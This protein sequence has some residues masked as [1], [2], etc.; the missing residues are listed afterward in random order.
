LTI[1][2]ITLIIIILLAIVFRSSGPETTQRERKTPSLKV[3][4]PRTGGEGGEPI[5]EIEIGSFFREEELSALKD[6]LKERNFVIV[7]GE[8]GAGKTTLVSQFVRGEKE[9]SV[10]WYTCDHRTRV[11]HL[12]GRL[13]GFLK[14][15]EDPYFEPVFE[16]YSLSLQEKIRLL[17][18]RLQEKNLLLVI[19]QIEKIKDERAR[20]ALEYLIQHLRLTRLILITSGQ[21]S[22]VQTDSGALFEIGGFNTKQMKLFLEALGTK[23]EEEMV[24]TI[25]QKVGSSPFALRLLAGLL[26]CYNYR[27]EEV[28]ER[29]QR[30]WPDLF[31]EIIQMLKSDEF[32]LLQQLAA[33]K[34]PLPEEGVKYLYRR[35][36]LRDVISLLLATNLLIKEG[37]YYSI[38][39][40]IKDLLYNQLTDRTKIHKALAHYYYELA[41]S[42]PYIDLILEAIH[43]LITAGEYESSIA[44]LLKES[45][46]VVKKGYAPI[47]LEYLNAYQREKILPK[48]WLRLLGLRGNVYKA[49]GHLNEAKRVYEEMLEFARTSNSRRGMS[50][51]YNNLGSIYQAQT[52]WGHAIDC[53]ER[54]LKILREMEPV[55]QKFTPPKASWVYGGKGRWNEAIRYYLKY[56]EKSL[57]DTQERGDLIGQATSYA[58]LGSVY[59][60]QGEWNLAI[61]HYNKCL[62]I[63]HR[64]DDPIAEA[65][66]YND[67][68]SVYSAKGDLD[69]AIPY[70]EK[71]LEIFERLDEAAGDS[72]CLAGLGEIY[73][74]KQDYPK[75]IFYYER[76]LEKLREMGD[77]PGEARCLVLL[78]NALRENGDLNRATECLRKSDEIYERLEGEPRDSTFYETASTIH[79]AK[80]DF[81]QAI[82]CLRIGVEMSNRDS[83]LRDEL[84]LSHKLGS[85][86]IKQGEFNEALIY[87]ERVM[88]ISQ[89]I[90]D[91]TQEA[92]GYAT[93]GSL[94]KKRREM[95]RAISSFQKAEDLLEQIGRRERLTQIYDE[96]ADLYQ[97]IGQVE[98]ASLYRTKRLN[99]SK[100]TA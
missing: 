56:Y 83:N 100:V 46:R 67:L 42:K 52:N 23:V 51:A 85:L 6:L 9:E 72:M 77:I 24:E 62:E 80:E 95:E 63:L 37:A 68:G 73:Y 29:T 32:T 8:E 43:H 60:A 58:N 79:L 78:A 22:E 89:A 44:I 17:A 45:K 76:R 55:R 50:E 5:P 84:N 96:L 81:S 36:D 74:E 13:N 48:D 53:Y 15:R 19:D 7:C 33:A 98:K 61:D 27:L 59:Q 82:E 10:F 57:K 12:L 69:R 34:E 86:L 94:F 25:S 99:G 18:R 30:G 41:D 91:K 38:H 3:F 26:N 66:C 71:G 93:L 39:P 75:S 97:Q 4:P 54:G 16:D 87:I 64:L 90:G 88:E 2:I 20:K 35:I 49:M 28:I 92:M 1:F 21:R 65:R 47:I 70:Y 31:R 14:Q 11:E 40:Q